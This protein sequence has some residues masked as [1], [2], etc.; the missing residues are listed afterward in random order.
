[1]KGLVPKVV[2]GT[3]GSAKNNNETWQAKELR[4]RFGVKSRPFLLCMLTVCETTVPAGTNYPVKAGNMVSRSRSVV[5]LAYAM[6][7]GVVRLA[8]CVYSI[9]MQR[10][11]EDP[12][13]TDVTLAP[14]PRWSAV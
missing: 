11:A 12:G 14:P 3:R 13:M 6:A 10:V 9:R 7:R 8:Y 4:Q 5:R 2:P 1:M